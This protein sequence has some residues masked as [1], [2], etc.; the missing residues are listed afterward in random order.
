MTRKQ[1]VKAGEAG[2]PPLSRFS[3]EEGLAAI[4]RWLAWNREKMVSCPHQ[5]GNLKASIDFCPRRRQNA[6]KK[7]EGRF[8]SIG[9]D[10]FK[11][12]GL[13]ICQKCRGNLGEAKTGDGGVE[14][15]TAFR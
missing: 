11:V 8:P 1:L 9:P 4:E 15:G 10:D 7:A 13:L 3:P 6:P 14:K 5:P 12:L 2:R